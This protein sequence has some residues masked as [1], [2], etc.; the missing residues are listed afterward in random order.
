MFTHCPMTCHAVLGEPLRVGIGIVQ[1]SYPWSPSW[2]GG[3]DTEPS[4]SL[5]QQ[6]FPSL[7]PGL[8][9]HGNLREKLCESQLGCW[10]PVTQAQFLTPLATT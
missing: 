9:V 7:P 3:I 5:P 4:L 2:A 10:S 8:T 6:R 1:Q